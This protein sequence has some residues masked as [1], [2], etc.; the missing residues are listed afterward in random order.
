ML[1]L[2]GRSGFFT[3]RHF[4]IYE[5]KNRGLVIVQIMIGRRASQPS[6]A[7][8]TLA[9]PL[10]LADE[11]RPDPRASFRASCALRK[12]YKRKAYRRR[13]PLS[14]STLAKDAEE[15]PRERSQQARPCAR[16]RTSNPSTPPGGVLLVGAKPGY[17]DQGVA[18]L[19]GS[20]LK[21]RKNG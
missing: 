7:E 9:C 8:R 17:R 10:L 16:P 11:S 2:N 19:W 18:G 20:G 4:S 1:G 5:M 3:Q 14:P 15:T 6:C 12:T 21:W 13:W